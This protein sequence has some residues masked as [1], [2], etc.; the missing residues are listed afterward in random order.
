MQA[1]F[2]LLVLHVQ[3]MAQHQL[4]EQT[5]SQPPNKQV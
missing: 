2:V 4:S 5:A 1:G 3:A